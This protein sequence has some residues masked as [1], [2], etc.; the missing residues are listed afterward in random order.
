MHRKY[1]RDGLVAISVSLDDPGESESARNT[2]ARALAFLKKQGAAFTNVLLDEP[3]ELYEAKL[4]I[5]GPP[6]IYIFN[7]DNRHVLKRDGVGE[8]GRIDYEFFEKT[9]QQLLAEKK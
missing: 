4:K 3:S 1:A 9:I 5:D 8:N 2:R 7:R 6:C